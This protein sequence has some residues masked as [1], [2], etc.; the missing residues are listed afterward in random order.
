M[1][2]HRRSFSALYLCVLLSACATGG[3]G[4]PDADR[5]QDAADPDAGPTDAGPTDAGPADAAAD[6]PPDEDGDG[7]PDARD[8]APSDPS[9]GNIGERSCESDCASGLEQCVDG[10]WSDCDAPTDCDCSDGETRELDCAM[11]GTQRQVC[12]TD[13]TWS[14]DG[15][16]S[17]QGPCTPGALESET[18]DECAGDG[19]RRRSCGDDCTWSEWACESGET[20][21]WV[22]PSGGT[23][24]DRFSLDPTSPSAPSA[25]VRAAFDVDSANEAYVLTGSS[26]HVLDLPSRSW[27]RSGPVSGPFPETG[28]ASVVSAYSVPGRHAGGTP[29]TESVTLLVDEGGTARVEIYD[30]V[31]DTR[32]F[33]HVDTVDP[34]CAEQWDGPLAPAAADVVAQWLDVD[35]ED[36]WPEPTREC[37]AGATAEIYFG[38]LSS[39]HVHVQDAGN[40]FEYVQRTVYGDFPPFGRAGAPPATSIGATF[41]HG[42]LYVLRTAP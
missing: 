23:E 9:V 22:H 29:G 11:C 10:V 33:T 7:V 41:W 16:C 37:D 39:T 15:T 31:A 19:A 28:G 32:T 30:Y 25:P 26:Y 38:A 2:H 14:D 42:G 27:T 21:L 8:C 4:S 34:C 24:W 17:D 5:G 3:S 13:G 6:A 1:H 36:G 35:N 40:C 12:G 20:R 18:T